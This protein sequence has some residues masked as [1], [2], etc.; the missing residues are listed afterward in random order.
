MHAHTALTYGR[1]ELSDTSAEP[2]RRP[3]RDVPSPRSSDGRGG[4][5]PAVG[6]GMRN[7]RFDLLRSFLMVAEE[8]QITRAASRLQVS[9]SGLSRRLR[10][11]E[12]EVGQ[13]LFVRSTRRVDLT[14]G[15]A[16]LLPHA[17]ALLRAAEAASRALAVH[18]T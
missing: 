16:A 17:V 9:Q 4:E 18:A 6:D 3:A 15:G 11:L 5:E 7:L 10:M 8:R 13:P 1:I 12:Q 2:H 14:P